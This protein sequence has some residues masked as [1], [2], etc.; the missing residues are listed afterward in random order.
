MANKTALAIC[1]S[2][3]DAQS[4]F[5]IKSSTGAETHCVCCDARVLSA[6]VRTYRGQLR[7][8]RRGCCDTCRVVLSN[9][10]VTDFDK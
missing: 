7:Y 1:A 9:C 3:R 8:P 4:S 5:W 10:G 2:W 6:G